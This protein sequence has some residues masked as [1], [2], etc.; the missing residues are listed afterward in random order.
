MFTAT[1]VFSKWSAVLGDEKLAAAVIDCIVH[2]GRLKEIRS[3][4]ERMGYPLMSGR[5]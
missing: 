4:S 5:Q 2:C 1:I 3:E